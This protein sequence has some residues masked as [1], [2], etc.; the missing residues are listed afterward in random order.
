MTARASF[1]ARDGR[2][3]TLNCCMFFAW[4]RQSEHAGGGYF[5]QIGDNVKRR[6]R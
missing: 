2:C 1:E 6:L 4:A 5:R 3:S